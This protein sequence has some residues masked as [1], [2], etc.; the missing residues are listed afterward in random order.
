MFCFFSDITNILPHDIFLCCRAVK[1]TDQRRVTLLIWKPSPASRIQ[2]PPRYQNLILSD[3]YVETTRYASCSINVDI[4]QLKY[5]HIFAKTVSGLYQHLTTARS[6]NYYFSL[7]SLRTFCLCYSWYFERF[8]LFLFY[9]C[10]V[11]FW[12]YF[13]LGD[14]Q[15]YLFQGNRWCWGWLC[16]WRHSRRSRW[17]QTQ[18]HRHGAPRHFRPGEWKHAVTFNSV[19]LWTNTPP[20]SSPKQ[21]EVI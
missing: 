16:S 20:S 19:K 8:F 17:R 11:L 9:F 5:C 3:R 13:S 12:P 4:N 1:A 10:L 14:L 18:W 21:D 2:T 15:C 7:P 6:F